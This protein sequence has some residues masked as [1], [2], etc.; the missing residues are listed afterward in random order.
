MVVSRY[1]F[2][3]VERDYLNQQMFCRTLDI[4]S[5]AAFRLYEHASGHA[6]QNADNESENE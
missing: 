3:G 2:S 5:N 1:V 4:R 6:A